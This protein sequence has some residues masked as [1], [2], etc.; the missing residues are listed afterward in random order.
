[1][2]DQFRRKLHEV[3]SDKLADR[4]Q[5]LINSD[6]QTLE[7]YKKQIGYIEALN[8]VLSWAEHIEQ[9]MYGSPRAA[10]NK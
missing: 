7:E 5:R 1:M 4:V 9:Q 6:L 2:I 10:D 3:V 8:D